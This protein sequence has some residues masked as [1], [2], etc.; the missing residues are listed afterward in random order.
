MLQLF[1][2]VFWEKE[3]IKTKEDPHAID[4]VPMLKRMVE[5]DFFKRMVEK[6][7]FEQKR[8]IKHRKRGE[9]HGRSLGYVRKMGVA[10]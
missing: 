3:K 10:K 9:R 1:K 8:K 4:P 7:N 6:V 2:N 5:R